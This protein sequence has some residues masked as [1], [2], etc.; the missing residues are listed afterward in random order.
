MDS[1]IVIVRSRHQMAI[2]TQRALMKVYLCTLT[3]PAS[4]IM[5]V[6]FVL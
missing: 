2:V 6:I 1:V 4:Y 3:L 5:L